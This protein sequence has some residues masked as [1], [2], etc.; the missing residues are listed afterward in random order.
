MDDGLQSPRFAHSAAGMASEREA[1]ARV[2]E[3]LP[4]DAVWE[5][6]QRGGGGEAVRAGAQARAVLE[7]ALVLVGIAAVPD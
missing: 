7:Y 4:P 5:G 3:D 1:A 2:R 6:A